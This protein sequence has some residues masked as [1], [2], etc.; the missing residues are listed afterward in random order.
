M[1]RGWGLGLGLYG[2]ATSC[3]ALGRRGVG[4]LRTSSRTAHDR[5]ATLCAPLYGSM[6]TASRDTPIFFGD[7]LEFFCFLWEFGV[8]LKTNSLA[9]YILFNGF[10]IKI[11][12]F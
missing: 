9:D 8:Y 11:Q 7:Y 4:G 1:G 5:R 2:M 3:L 10:H 12:H 6:V